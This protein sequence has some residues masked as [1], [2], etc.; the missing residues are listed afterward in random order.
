[1]RGASFSADEKRILFSS[2]ET[3]LFNVYAIAAAGGK[4]EALTKSTTDSNYSL[5]FFPDDDRMLYTRDSGGDELNHIYVREKD[6]TE[7]DLTP[8][9]KLKANFVGWRR[10]GSAFYITT[11]ERDPKFNDIYKYDAKT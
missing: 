5:A 6:G 4:S 11:N 7:R 1:M 8:G 10:D 9:Q 3:G 2:N